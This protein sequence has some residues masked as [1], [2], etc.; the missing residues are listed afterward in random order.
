M[1]RKLFLSHLADSNHLVGHGI[2]DV[3]SPDEGIVLFT[4]VY[5]LHPFHKVDIQACATDLGEYPDGN[6]FMLCTADETVHHVIPNALQRLTE[7]AHG[8]SLSDLFSEVSE[9]L[10]TAVSAGTSL[11]NTPDEKVT[12]ENDFDF[13]FEGE[14]SDSDFFGPVDRDAVTG[15]REI[16][17]DS[18]ATAGDA[19]DKTTKIR[20]DLNVL[21]KAG[22]RV[23]V[24]GNLSA[25]GIL[26]VSIRVSKLGLSDEALEAWN[27]PRKRYLVLLIRY[28]RGYRDATEIQA[29]K[30]LSS[31][32]QM[33]VGL[34]EHY[35]PSLT[36]V[37][38]VFQ[39][40]KSGS[41]TTKEQGNNIKDPIMIDDE[42]VF[43]T[44]FI[45]RAINQLLEERLFQII[46]A[47]HTCGLTWLGAEKFISE[48]QASAASSHSGDLE[49]YLVDDIASAQHL[50]SIVHGD[51][52]TQTALKE[53]SLPLIIMQ[54]VLRHV[55]RCT[56]F[57]L[58]CHCR[59][60]EDSDSIEALKPYVCLKPLCLFQ[61]LTLGF[62]PSLEWEIL[63]QP[64]VVD[65]LVSFCYAAAY[66]SR[67]KELPLGMNLMVPMT[68]NQSAAV[69]DY[70]TQ[71]RYL[72]KQNL[73][74]PAP[75]VESFTCSWDV[76]TLRL[77]VKDDEN[78]KI[79]A[80]KQAD[81]QNKDAAMLKHVKVGD[82]LFLVSED[83]SAS[84]HC[85]VKQVNLPEISVHRPVVVGPKPIG[86]GQDSSSKP[87]ED[88]QFTAPLADCYLYDQHFDDIPTA[89]QQGA[90]LTLLDTLPG[91]VE[92]REYL[93]RQQRTPDS[94][95]KAWSDRISDP[96][97][98]LLRWIVAS[99]RSCI[100]QVD[101]ICGDDG[102]TIM[103]RP[104]DR[105]GG[106]DAWMQFR[107]AQGAPDKEKRFNTC[108]KQQ[109][110]ATKTA[111]P[112]LFAWHGSSVGNWHSIIRQGLRF[113]VSSL[114]NIRRTASL[115]PCHLTPSLGY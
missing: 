46:S 48:R 103:G 12:G 98:N 44:L 87:L 76:A 5:P 42:V 72:Q 83:R 92:M 15:T 17:L 3:R 2:H 34:C 24:F 110:L 21:K 16:S 112:T 69:T 80:K 49:P 90:I 43:E 105:V 13:D 31:S 36:Q 39:H 61:Y 85:R 51:H 84:A 104:E 23:G 79:I 1:G 81:G 32:V 11:D 94:S 47:R 26:C 101:E 95:L 108:V 20:A 113:D 60:D 82:W 59:V 29:F 77:V 68:Q 54:F 41:V 106:M 71:S 33:K 7:S 65:L 55:V 109:A 86:S 97:L 107:F 40:A 56:E 18:G 50:P 53:A 30:E 52:M 58:V 19:M 91:V 38:G 114:L 62:G 64:Y 28:S 73:S 75:P 66:S 35:K 78:C 93:L 10:T 89:A 63:T 96:A 99:N 74:A 8:K 111:Y 45:G 9:A 25:S 102:S 67:L 6:S 57:C 115:F 37:V 88:A 22:F 27:I 100:L 14:D 70:T 4:Y